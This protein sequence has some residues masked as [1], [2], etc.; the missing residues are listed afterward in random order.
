[1]ER[2]I[3]WDRKIINKSPPFI[4]SEFVRHD[5]STEKQRQHLHARHHKMHSLQEHGKELSLSPSPAAKIIT[6]VCDSASKI[7]RTCAVHR[8][9]NK[10]SSFWRPRWARHAWTLSCRLSSF[11]WWFFSVVWSPAASVVGGHEERRSRR[12]RPP[13]WRWPRTGVSKMGRPVDFTA[14]NTPFMNMGT[15]GSTRRTT[16]SCRSTRETCPWTRNTATVKKV[17]FS[18]FAQTLPNYSRL[19][20][21]NLQYSFKRC[22]NAPCKGKFLDFPCGNLKYSV[23][24][25]LSWRILLQFEWHEAL[26][27]TFKNGLWIIRIFRRNILIS[28]LTHLCKALIRIRLVKCWLKY[29]GMSQLY[30][31]CI[32]MEDLDSWPSSIGLLT[33]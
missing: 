30:W 29:S 5:W 3:V 25:F 27:F 11:S 31:Y 14:A 12:Q 15:M 28:W 10:A 26:T 33:E 19:S 16:R 9:T 1:M 18:C 22:I 32:K 20:W 8:W 13:I 21:G 7:S 6:F 2:N 24:S 23:K 4:G 17:P